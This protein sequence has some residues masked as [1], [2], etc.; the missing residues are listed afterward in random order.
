MH[1]QRHTPA[2]S[3]NHRPWMFLILRGQQAGGSAVT[4]KFGIFPV[5]CGKLLLLLLILMGGN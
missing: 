5:L 4:C 2:M 3:R 1:Y